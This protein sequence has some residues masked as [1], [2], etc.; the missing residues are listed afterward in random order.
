MQHLREKKDTIS[1][2][3]FSQVVQ[4]QLLDEVGN[5]AYFDCVLS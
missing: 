4:K 2:F 5:E 3:L 1:K